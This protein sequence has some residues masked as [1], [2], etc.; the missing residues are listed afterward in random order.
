MAMTWNS[1]TGPKTTAGSI[2]NWVSWSKIDINTILDEAQTLIYSLLR[3]REM[4][5]VFNFTIPVDNAFVALPSQFLDPIGDIQFTSVN[6]EPTHRDNTYVRNQRC[7]QETSGTLLTNPFT[8]VLGSSLVTVVL[9][10]HGFRQ[11]SL[12]FTAGGTAT[13]GI[14]IAG[15]YEIVAITSVNAFV[16]D[17]KTPAAAAATGGGA[18]ATYVCQNLTQGSPNFWGIWDERIQFDMAFVAQYSGRLAYY[19]SLPLLSA[20]NP[21][22]FLTNRYPGMVRTACQASAADYMKDDGEYQKSM[23]RLQAWIERA[24]V[25]NDLLLRGAFIETETP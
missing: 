9:A 20:S 11:G 22:N 14:A 16:I 19:Q 4:E 25:E 10:G 2:I 21:T 18:A 15:T 12:F 24:Q 23:T 1:L 17:V 13:G 3:I 8:T 6:F 5:T 7:Y